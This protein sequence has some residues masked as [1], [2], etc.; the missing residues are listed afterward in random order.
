[1]DATT[2]DESEARFAAIW[3]GALARHAETHGLELDETKSPK[4]RSAE[5][6]LRELDNQQARF[7][8]FRQKRQK[9]YQVLGAAL[10]P[11]ELLAKLAAGSSKLSWPPGEVVFN[12]VQYLINASHGV[13][14]CYDAIIDLFTE[15]KDFM[16]RLS[17]HARQNVSQELKEISASILMSLIRICDLSAKVIKSGRIRKYVKTVFLGGDEDVRAEL[18][19]LRRLTE[20]EEGMVGALTLSAVTDIND[21]LSAMLLESA[22]SRMAEER[23][24]ERPSIEKIR[25]CLK[26]STIPREIFDSMSR[27][28]VQG[29]GDWIHAEPAFE[30][31]A[32]QATPILWL[33]G[34]PGSGK[35]FLSAN[36][37][38]YLQQLYPQQLQSLEHVSIAYFFCKEYD[39]D[40]RSFNKALRSIAYQICLQDSV[41][42]T[43]CMETFAINDSLY[44]MHAL[45][46]QLFLDFFSASSS[47]SIVMV[48]IDGLDEADKRERDEFLELLHDIQES[49]SF[50]ER[51]RIHLIMLGRPEINWDIQ[52]TLG[53]SVPAISLSAEQTSYDL[54]EYVIRSVSKVRLLKQVP[55]KLRQEVIDILVR[56]ADGM[57]LWVDF[58][59]KEISSQRRV[60]QL[61]GTLSRL[62]R[63][64]SDTIS[65]VLERFSSTLEEEEIDDL[66]H[67]LA[68]VVCAR[69]QLTLRNLD[70]VLRVKSPGCE[71]VIDL[72]GRILGLHNR[73]S[74]LSD[75]RRAS[76]SIR[77]VLLAC[78]RGWAHDRGPANS[79]TVRPSLPR[80]RQTV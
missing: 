71:G 43:H 55:Q 38:Q 4:H 24:N 6:L 21:K 52:Q 72:E 76:I 29:S 33:N 74:T 77:F 39:D 53:N 3:A 41:Y 42:A 62:P 70:T 80:R 2:A 54:H 19:R 64:L 11:V 44:S 25:K 13:S 10:R 65:G 34:A 23:V 48:L 35:S 32:K 14:A 26:P 49:D 28:R 59:I 60:E 56:G 63:G 37:I 5:S 17:V 31:W 69:R 75:Y 57:F 16:T 66:N 73:I 1:M 30:S 20:S 79:Y 18:T 7:S 58:M 68:W 9:L 8:D 61:R 22:Q 67:L 51:A 36:I 45:W 15:I 78:S 46:K 50:A 12:A 47:D 40:L 27:K